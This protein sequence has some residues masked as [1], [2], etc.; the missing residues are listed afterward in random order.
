MRGAVATGTYGTNNAN[1]VFVRLRPCVVRVD[2]RHTIHR[3]LLSGSDN[4]PDDT[5]AAATEASA[6]D[7]LHDELDGAV[8]GLCHSR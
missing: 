4:R 1:Q 7:L 3:V 2:V 8:A 6:R 5:D